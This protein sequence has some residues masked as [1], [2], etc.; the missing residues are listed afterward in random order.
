MSTVSYDIQ[1]RSC[2]MTT[3]GQLWHGGQT[4]TTPWSD[5]AMGGYSTCGGLLSFD[6]VAQGLAQTSK[7]K[8][9]AEPGAKG[10][11]IVR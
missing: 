2:P 3:P 6:R 5:M 11:V 8:V 9:E 1:R 4:V 10:I 7:Q